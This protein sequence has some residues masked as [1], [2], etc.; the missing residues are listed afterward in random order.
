[1]YR[2]FHAQSKRVS[3][4]V[5]SSFFGQLSIPSCFNC[6]L[7]CGYPGGSR[8]FVCVTRHFAF[9]CSPFTLSICGTLLAACHGDT[10]GAGFV[11]GFQGTPHGF[12]TAAFG[13]V[14]RSLVCCVCLAWYGYIVAAGTG[15]VKLFFAIFRGSASC[16]MWEGLHCAKCYTGHGKQG[17]G[18]KGV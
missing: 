11:F 8:L 18:C 13:V 17:N 9:K 15:K 16:T 2:W 3:E 5:A 1:M 7:L 10:F 4:R 12:Y 6:F 14:A